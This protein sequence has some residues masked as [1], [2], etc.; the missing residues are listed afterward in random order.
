MLV[1]RMKIS[2]AF[3]LLAAGTAGGLLSTVVSIASLVSYP[4]LLALG[5]SPLSANMTNTVSLVLTGA[6]SVA[7]SRPELSGQRDR[8]LRYGTI[9]ALG[10]GAGAAVLLLAPAS[11]FTEVAPVLIGGASVLLLI[12]PRLTLLAPRPGQMPPRTGQ[13]TPRPGLPP[14]GRP[15]TAEDSDSISAAQP[16]RRRLTHIGALFVVAVYV[17]YFGAAAGV[18]LLIVLSTMI[19]EPLVR[20][21]AI[22]NAVSGAANAMAAICFAI[23]GS[24][25]WLFVGPLAAGFLLG[26]WLGP[27]IARRVPA[28]MLRIVVSLCGIALAV[29]LGITAY[30]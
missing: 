7:G 23:F 4:V 28:T 17:G 26:G 20:V 30:R 12:Q 9:T 1:L 8:L 13:V 19:A 5:V 16:A 14:P 11:T 22:K 15:P 21:N 24:V 25:R 10:G 27:K 18:M 29:R 2:E 6:G 3:V